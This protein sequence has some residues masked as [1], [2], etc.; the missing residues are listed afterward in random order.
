[1]SAPDTSA[2]AGQAQNPAPPIPQADPSTL[3]SAATGG[4]AQAAQPSPAP[5]LWHRVLEG[6]LSGLAHGGVAGALVGGV[7]SASP[8]RFN[9]M[10]EQQQ[11]RQKNAE[12]QSAQQQAAVQQQQS[13]IRFTDANAANTVADAHMK[14]AQI[15]ALPQQVQDQHTQNAVNVLKDL[16]PTIGNPLLIT[17]YDPNDKTAAGPHA[18]MDQLGKMYP[19]GI[20]TLTTFHVGD[21]FISYDAGQIAG[22]PSALGK[23]NESRTA[24]GLDPLSQTQYAGMPPAAKAN[25]I[26]RDL[27]DMW[28]PAPGNNSTEAASKVQQYKQWKQTYAARPDANPDVLKRFDNTIQALDASQQ[29]MKSNDLQL[30]GARASAVQASTEPTKQADL[31]KTAI[32]KIWTDPSK[33]YEAALTQGNQTLSAIK[34]GADGNGL[35]TSLTPTMEILGVNHAAGI[36][37]ISPAEMQAA[38]MPGSL[39]ERW[40][41]WATKA[42]TGQLSPQLAQEG[43]QLMS[44]VLD[45]AHQKA[46]QSSQFVAKSRGIDPAQ[47]PA[48]DRQGNVTTLDKA[49]A[50]YQRNP[51]TGQRRVSYDGRKTWQPVQ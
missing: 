34:A 39:A 18:A 16:S 35:L 38:G 9:Q 44:T 26:K 47:T 7:E 36:N 2:L 23:L 1:M 20:P 37:R 42:S 43:Q 31:G 10:Q 21:K 3:Q 33:G 51:A 17:D 49:N 5:G 11:L 48:M 19:N 29:A 14:Q 6:A 28:T 15:D 41:A 25:E 8:T 46:I 40:N 32:E 45:A 24:M 50:V 4:V 13:Q 22:N 12:A 30:A 27:E